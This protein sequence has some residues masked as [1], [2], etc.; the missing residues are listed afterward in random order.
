MARVQQ[1]KSQSL[2]LGGPIRGYSPNSKADNIQINAT[3]GEWLHP[4]ETVQYYGTRTM[5]AIRQRLIPKNIL[6]NIMG[7]SY[8]P[9]SRPG[10][11]HYA[12]GGPVS[13]PSSTSAGESKQ[14]PT[15]L[16]NLNILDPSLINQ[17]ARSTTGT[18]TFL[19][20]ITENTFQ[21]KQILQQG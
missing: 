21:I 4:V 5:E 10:G 11:N 3:A 13:G 9:T 18:Q 2:A 15:I 1:I 17:W 6:N 16:N 19:N 8:I 7:N 20:V 12:S 14:S